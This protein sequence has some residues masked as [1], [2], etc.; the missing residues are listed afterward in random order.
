MAWD[1]PSPTITGGF[2][3]PSKGRFIHPS[4]HRAIT[5]REGA[6]LQSFP[7]SYKFSLS[8]GK[9]P[10]A[11]MIGNAFPPELATRQARTLRKIMNANR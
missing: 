11:R 5:L 3:N 7:W 8:R 6:L 9:F 1:V 10:C 2:V 4:E